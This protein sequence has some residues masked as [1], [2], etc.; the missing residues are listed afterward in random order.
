MAVNRSHFSVKRR[1]L[2]LAKNESPWMEMMARSNESHTY[3]C[4]YDILTLR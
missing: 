4:V 2:L 3:E 1:T